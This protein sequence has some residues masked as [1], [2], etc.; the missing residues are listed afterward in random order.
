MNHSFPGFI[1][2]EEFFILAQE[3]LNG[4]LGG[5]ENVKEVTTQEIVQS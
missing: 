5:E 3:K 1:N 4:F 2:F